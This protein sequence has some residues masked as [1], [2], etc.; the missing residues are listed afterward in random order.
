[1]DIPYVL[2]EFVMFYHYSCDNNTASRRIGET[3]KV[4]DAIS[5]GF[6]VLTTRKHFSEEFV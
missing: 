3:T 5:K 2:H 6:H 4:F 1:M